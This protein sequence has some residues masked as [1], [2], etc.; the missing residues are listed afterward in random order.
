MV[1]ADDPPI[2]MDAEG[3]VTRSVR[4]TA[5]LVDLLDLALAVV[6]GAAVAAP[7]R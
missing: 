7:A 6:A 3:V 5:A 4:D 1:S 2:G